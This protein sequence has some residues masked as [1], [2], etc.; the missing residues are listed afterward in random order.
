M[1]LHMHRNMQKTL[2]LAFFRDPP[3]TPQNGLKS[4]ILTLFKKQK[5]GIR[6]NPKNGPFWRFCRFLVYM[7]SIIIFGP[8]WQFR[9][10][11]MSAGPPR[12]PQN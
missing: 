6:Q 9:E 7:V 5:G 2:F 1:F 8:T 3:K 12:D 10:I 11:A 4:S